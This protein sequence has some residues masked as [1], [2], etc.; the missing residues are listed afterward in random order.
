[1]TLLDARLAELAVAGQ[2]TT[3]GEL[4]RDLGMRMAA[5]TAQLEAIMEEDAVAGKPFRATLCAGRLLDGQPAAGFFLKAAQLGRL[6][7]EASP[8]E[9]ATFVA[10][11]RVALFTATR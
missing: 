8:A 11:E 2:T 4:A 5:L 9:K 3:Y 10:A 1:M 7:P 6:S